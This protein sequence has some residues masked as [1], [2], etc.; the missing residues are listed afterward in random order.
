MEYFGETPP[1]LP[2]YFRYLAPT[3]IARLACYI[4]PELF[5][6]IADEGTYMS[7]NLE[8]TVA[9][10]AWK[11]YNQNVVSE[12]NELIQNINKT[13]NMHFPP[14][15]PVLIFTTKEEKVTQDGKNNVTFYKT[16]LTDV[17]TSK[18]VTYKGHHYLH[19]TRYKEMSEEINEF[20]K[21]IDGGL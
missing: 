17:P 5:L 21:A 11:G 12:A 4:S 19:W 2:T 7:E 13:K 20:I 10:S 9:I 16:Q 6:P 8:M 14:N 1:E 3:G 18:I 15:M